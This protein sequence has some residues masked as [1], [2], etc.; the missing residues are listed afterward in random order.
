MKKISIAIG[1]I[2]LILSI[3]YI[4]TN[5]NN[6][7]VATPPVA[8]VQNNQ[9]AGATASNPEALADTTNTQT[10]AEQDVAEENT[11]QPGIY[12]TYDEEQIAASEADHIVLFFHATWC[13]SCR[14]LDNDIT[15]NAEDIPFGVE[16]YKLDYDTETE[17]KRQ[18]GITTQHS[19]V[20]IDSNG[21]ATSA[22]TH[23]ITFED[24][25]A[26]L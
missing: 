26:T 4:A 9:Q 20:E 21:T 7:P 1:V 10:Q 23:P 8:N 11:S 19:I 6:E 5:S 16:I 24:M 2:V 22:I 12:T 15:A 14:A 25:L 18:Y 13:P 3:G 17:L